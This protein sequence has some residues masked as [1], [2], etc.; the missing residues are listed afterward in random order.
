MKR[1]RNNVRQQ[2]FIILFETVI[3]E[4]SSTFVEIPHDASEASY[5]SS[6]SFV[7]L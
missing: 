5:Q 2:Q 6:Y 4:E 1:E 3:R 7:I